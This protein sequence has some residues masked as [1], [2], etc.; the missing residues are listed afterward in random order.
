MSD[1]KITAEPYRG[2]RLLVSIERGRYV[3][4]F[5]VTTDE[6]EGLIETLRDSLARRI[7]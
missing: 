6:A 5:D 2:D 4:S 3:T 1:W 7:T